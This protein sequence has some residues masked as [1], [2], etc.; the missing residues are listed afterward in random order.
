[1]NRALLSTLVVA[2]GATT[3]CK[4]SEDGIA[5]RVAELE[6]R[7]NTAEERAAEAELQAAEARAERE[8]ALRQLEE[9]KLAAERDAIERERTL[10]EER[11]LELEKLDQ[12]RREAAA[13]QLRLR[14]ET[15]GGREQAVEQLQATL[16]DKEQSLQEQQAQ[17]NER[18][19]ALA[20]REAVPGPDN[21]QP[22]PDFNVP[23]VNV[24]YGP[25]GSYGSWFESP[26]YGY[27]WRPAVYRTTGWR[28]YTRGRWACT[29]RGWM[30]VSD[31]PFGWATY[32][33][34]RWAL[35]RNF[36]WIWVPGTEWAPSWVCWR[37]GG[38]YT[39]WA[40]LPPETM[41]YRGHR[42]DS[43]V[44]VTFGIGSLWFNFV[45]TRYFGRPILSYCLPPARNDLCWGNTV[46]ITNIHVINNRVI[47]GGP[48]YGDVAHQ[49][50]RRP[51]FYRIEEDRHGRG[52][53]DPAPGNH[54]IRNGRLVVTPPRRE[55][56]RNPDAIKPPRI[57]GRLDRVEIERNKQ[58][59]PEIVREFQKNRPGPSRREE[60]KPDRKLPE[61]TDRKPPSDR[62][63]EQRKLNQHAEDLQKDM[64]KNIDD[65]IRVLP[66]PARDT[67]DGNS[68]VRPPKDKTDG[69][70]A[71]PPSVQP[72]RRPTTRGEEQRK[73]NE[74][75]E[76]LQDDMR[77]NVDDRIRVLPR[78]ADRG[79]ST[80][81]SPEPPKVSPEL[82]PPTHRLLTEP[83]VP[84]TR[85]EEPRVLPRREEP[86][87]GR[88]DQTRQAE[89]SQRRMQQAQEENLRRQQRQAEE[90]Q[91]QRRQAAEQQM[92]M[93]AQRQQQQAAE[94]QARAQQQRQ[95]E[96]MQRRQQ[97][98]MEESRRQQQQRQSEELQ[99]RQAED[100]Q[101]RN[102]RR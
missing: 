12:E 97:Q 10:I 73:L 15:L 88:A 30:W 43:S 57:N 90:L 84:E 31:E 76:K 1:M 89:E 46:N 92:R 93:E 47:C 19:R 41:A 80:P 82:P 16:A 69:G 7:A 20:G 95:A 71:T 100:Q 87:A 75:A 56:S 77:K 4:K 65:R 94:Q 59:D 50:D 51:P 11:R 64:R 34:G 62:G 48:S 32:H 35:C 33:Y 96:E 22:A 38:S 29:D 81:A 101:R 42:W 61:T 52:S 86:D 13:E 98:A 2:L 25:L 44:E 79:T 85:R 39:G 60:E 8:K 72:D 18:D 54:R 67:T 40:P 23:N 28:P 99:R 6:K 3:A 74:H 83:R 58:I 49:T 27:V 21:G 9:Q 14:E 5:A 78:P 26:D 36:G 66:R 37:H 70:P 68:P 17:L 55:E 102:Q 63:E 45:E 53:L 24:F 91:Q